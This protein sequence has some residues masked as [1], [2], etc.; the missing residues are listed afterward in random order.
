M[1]LDAHDPAHPARAPAGSRHLTNPAVPACRAGTAVGVVVLVGG[2]YVYIR[3][4]KGW[5]LADLMYVS[6]ATLKGFQ[7]RVQEGGCTAAAATPPVAQA[8]RRGRALLCGD[9]PGDGRAR[10][11][12]PPPGAGACAATGIAA[13]HAPRRPGCPTL[14]G[15]ADAARNLDKAK[16]ELQ[17][18]LAQ[19]KGVQDEVNEKADRLDVMLGS[20]GTDVSKVGCGAAV[21]PHPRSCRQLAGMQL[22]GG[23][24]AWLTPAAATLPQAPR[25][26]PPAVTAD[27]C[28]AHPSARC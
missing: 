3:F 21:P 6:N 7:K 28:A 19:L 1:A 8:G 17:A 16:A 24:A 20:V 10:P 22:P 13:I 12:R 9:M 4:V 2:A 25:V 18:L 15:M 27:G 23:K 5:S 26:L 11:G 14:A